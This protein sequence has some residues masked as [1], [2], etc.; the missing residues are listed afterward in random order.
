MS[1]Q[2]LGGGATSMTSCPSDHQ[3]FGLLNEQLAGT[4][5]AEIVAHVDACPRCEA[6]LAELTRRG[7]PHRSWIAVRA[8]RGVEN[9]P[10][11][12][13]ASQF[14]T[15]S[16]AIGPAESAPSAGPDRTSD[17]G[18][19]AEL[20]T[21]D[22]PPSHAREGIGAPLE[23][24]AVDSQEAADPRAST[25]VLPTAAAVRGPVGASTSETIQGASDGPPLV[26]DRT[27]K[28]S[29]RSDSSPGVRPDRA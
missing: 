15:G 19:P 6:R 16:G 28:P 20:A 17:L 2:R 27:L 1:R 21:A 8:A 12:P 10:A 5:E 9:G 18:R 22:D 3:L 11:M 4:D 14:E 23:S 13:G 25:D 7:E 26:D 24:T 29:D